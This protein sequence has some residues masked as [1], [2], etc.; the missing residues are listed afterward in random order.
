MSDPLPKA[1]LERITELLHRHS[2]QYIIIGGQ[3]EYIFGSP[4][5]TYDI[6]LCYRR[7]PENLTH[8]AAALKELNVTLRGVPKDVP[9]VLDAK[10]LALGSNYTLV[11]PNDGDLDLLGYVEPLGDYDRLNKNA[12]DYQLGELQVRVIDL[13]DLITVKKHINRSKDR[14]SLLQLL[15][16][17]RIREE[18]GQR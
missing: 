11:T 6:D 10:A 4:R 17:K 7:T 15:A 9:V 3:A 14:E 18:T 2:V 12:S 8:L 16:I 5:V 13:D 1:R